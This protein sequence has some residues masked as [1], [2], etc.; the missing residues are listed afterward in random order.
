MD[1]RYTGQ[2]YHGNVASY[3]GE[4]QRFIEEEC[5]MVGSFPSPVYGMR[6]SRYTGTEK[7]QVRVYR[8][9]PGR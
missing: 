4:M 6:I 2:S 7:W 9:L 1:W 3:Y 8:V 5:R